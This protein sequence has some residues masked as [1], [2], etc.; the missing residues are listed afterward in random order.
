MDGASQQTRASLETT[1]S[2]LSTDDAQQP[3]DFEPQQYSSVRDTSLLLRI[4]PSLLFVYVWNSQYLRHSN[5][6]TVSSRTFVVNFDLSYLITNYA[7]RIGILQASRRCDFL[8]ANFTDISV[9]STPTPK[10]CLD[11][12]C[13]LHRQFL[14]SASSMSMPPIIREHCLKLAVCIFCQ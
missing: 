2:L 11:C 13:R 10:C 5:L 7:G 8:I 9:W 12:F 4:G 3:S 6:L 14:L 1:T